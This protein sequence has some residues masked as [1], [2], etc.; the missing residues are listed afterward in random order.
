MIVITGASGSLGRLVID[1]LAS[2]VDPNTII[3][4]ARSTE[5][6]ADLAG[7]GIQVRELD[8]NRPDSI[9]SALVGA[10]QIL[11]I[12]SSEVGQRVP[13]HQAVIDA[14]VAAGVDHVAYTSLLKADTSSIMLADEHRAT[15]AALAACG[16]T[17]TLLRNSWYVENYTENLGP[18][19]ENGA[20]VGSTRGGR[21]AAATRRDLAAAAATVLADDSKWGATYELGG[22]AFTMSDLAAAVG[23]ATGREIGYVDLPGDAHQGILVDAGLPPEMAAFLVDADRGIAAGDL[24]TDAAPLETLVGRPLGTLEQAVTEALEG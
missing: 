22:P 23:A 20:F 9:A 14:A 21:I 24:D 18:A 10:T 11:L 12:S 7:R 5:K 15:E 16:L 3:A 4:T 19:L 1:E 8:Y 13:Q 6:L 2:K 17:A